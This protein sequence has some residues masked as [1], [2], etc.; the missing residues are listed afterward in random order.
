MNAT[1][2]CLQV[3]IV[4]ASVATIGG[5]ASNESA[6]LP[7]TG[8]ATTSDVADVGP[9]DVGTP[10]T[11][12]VVDVADV[13]DVASPDDASD[14]AAS[15]A[16]VDA[17]VEGGSLTADG[18]V[19]RGKYAVLGVTTDDWIALWD[20]T[21]VGYAVSLATHE[22]R[23]V[24]AA[25]GFLIQGP[26]FF[27]WSGGTIFDSWRSTTGTAVISSIADPDITT[28]QLSADLAHVSFL[29]S[30]VESSTFN[31]SWRLNVSA[32]DGSGHVS[33]GTVYGSG[34]QTQWVGDRLIAAYA[35][36]AT[37]LPTQSWTV[38]SFTLA[39][40]R[41]E[42]SSGSS[43]LIGYFVVDPSGAKVLVFASDGSASVVAIDGSG[44]VPVAPHLGPAACHFTPDGASIVYADTATHALSRVTLGASPVVLGPTAADFTLSPDGTTVAGY[45]KIDSTY[46]LGDLFLASAT[47]PGAVT[48]LSTANDVAFQSVAFTP[49]GKRVLWVDGSTLLPGTYSSGTL[50]VRELATGVTTTIASGTFG[51]TPVTGSKYLYA[52]YASATATE[53]SLYLVDATAPTTST[54]LATNVDDG[55]WTLAP[56]NAYVAYPSAPLGGVAVVHLP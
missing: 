39:G 23:A 22:V 28:T 21:S 46:H 43:N 1:A 32:P 6:R 30:F 56:S 33:L 3:S 53:V 48:T 45:T 47:T 38:S 36:S 29:D 52:K 15:D 41:A 51:V 17:G 4:V 14:G 31:P 8:D 50:H 27:R 35:S 55:E 9:G 20:S 16:I 54:L 42:L 12:S 13:T 7:S 26:Y 11:T 37:V 24:G 44:R 19:V 34:G 2:L 40:A 49:D 5:C 18:L 10:D 25:A